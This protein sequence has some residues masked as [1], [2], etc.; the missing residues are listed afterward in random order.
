MAK[1]GQSENLRLAIIGVGA[2]GSLFG[3]RLS[4]L[5][6]LVMFGN[7]PEQLQAIRQDGL[8]LIDPNRR[9]SRHHVKVA[10]QTS[11]RQVFDVALVLVKSWQTERAARQA[12]ELL[13][14]DGLAVTLQNGLGNVDILGTYVGHGRA[15][16]GVTSEGAMMIGPGVVRHAGTGLT[17]L[18]ATPQTESR[19]HLLADLFGRAGFVTELTS[20][21]EGL[22]WGKLSINAG[23]NPLTAL[24]Q[25]TNGFLA[26]DETACQLMCL[27]AEETQ[28]VAQAQGITL[29]FASA[30]ERALEVA[31][32]TAANRS[33]MAQDVVRGMPTEIEAITGQVVQAGQQLGVPVP[34]NEALLLLVRSLLEDGS[35][36][37][38]I[39]CVSADLQ[40]HFRRLA[41]LGKSR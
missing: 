38:A 17:H 33:S 34:V 32:A 24:L 4:S 16:L 37:P 12:S 21:P 29:P 2:M 23:I 11:N 41:A 13:S 20:D 26:E 31:R 39:D 22:V 15:A 30:A 7:W 6:E 1:P 5:T 40:H 8:L 9:Q 36:Q 25:V 3:C 14:E 27:A 18:A 35:W 10:S 19:L 28:A